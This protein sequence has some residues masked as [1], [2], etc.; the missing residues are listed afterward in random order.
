M[1]M[2]KFF[3]LL[4][5]L[6]LVAYSSVC[7]ADNSPWFD[8]YPP[9]DLFGFKLG[10]AY[11]FS[12]LPHCDE[13]KTFKEGFPSE[14]FTTSGEEL[15]G[16]CVTRSS[17]S[18]SL[19]TGKRL[20]KWSLIR[21]PRAGLS[22]VRVELEEGIAIAIEAQG[23]VALKFAKLGDGAVM[24]GS[25][26]PVPQYTYGSVESVG[27]SAMAPVFVG[28]NPAWTSLAQT[29]IDKHTQY[30]ATLLGTLR[31]EC[32]WDGRTNLYSPNGLLK[33]KWENSGY[34]YNLTSDD[35]AT[36]LKITKPEYYTAR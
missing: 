5:S 32:G 18:L 1:R 24:E 10:T 13:N 16:D 2:Y 19:K 20:E 35:G 11:D 7:G 15:E 4:S 8:S 27:T 25:V 9:P 3:G 12:K 28:G 29:L 21:S 14:F 17:A 36:F 26:L 22:I 23:S 6:V 30:W 31:T 33:A 34:S